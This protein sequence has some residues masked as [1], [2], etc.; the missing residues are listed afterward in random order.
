MVTPLDLFPGW[1]PSDPFLVGLVVLIAA[2]LLMNRGRWWFLNVLAQDEP[3]MV[4][5]GAFFM[6]F[7]ADIAD[8]VGSG[9]SAA[10]FLLGFTISFLGIY[11]W[12][13]PRWDVSSLIG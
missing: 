10:W 2:V 4:A 13:S 11:I 7:S 9:T 6:A 3:F 8:K 5:V 12:W 1:V